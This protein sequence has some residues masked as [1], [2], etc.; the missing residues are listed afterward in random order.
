MFYHYWEKG[1]KEHVANLNE[2]DITNNRKFCHTVKPLLTDKNKFREN[3][4]LVNN[5]QITS[6]A[7]KIANT[8]NSF[9]Q[10]SLKTSKFLNT[11]LKIN[12]H[13]GFQRT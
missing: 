6:D 3:I 1:K 13:I 4:I 10:A 9:S 8:L 11:M 12:F 7:V 5:E 2:K